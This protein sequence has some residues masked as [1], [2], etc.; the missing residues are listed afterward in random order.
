MNKQLLINGGILVAGAGLGFGAGY[1]VFKKKYA[2][3]A[4]AEIA[5][6]RDSYAK[7]A[8]NAAK[9]D[10]KDFN[11]IITPNVVKPAVQ[12]DEE[13]VEQIIHRSNYTS[14]GVVEAESF[15]AVYG[16]VPTTEELEELSGPETNDSTPYIFEG[17]IFDSPEPDPETLGEGVD[18]V[19]PRS[20]DR[21]YVIK[22]DE[23]YLNETNYDQITLTWWADDDVLAD[24]SQHPILDIESAVGA[25]NL[26][27]FGFLSMDPDIVY[28]RNEKL[29]V[30]YEITKD[31]RNFAEVVHGVRSDEEQDNVLRRMRSNDE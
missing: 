26:H 18:E 19:P 8:K 28:V 6:V 12:S 22:L 15:R 24:D 14:E 17:N 25:T 16:R 30:D 27:R 2:A 7:A 21:P 9:A 3:I 1:F 5:S 13:R 20:P 29:K 10:P 11:V 23:W 4:D 31:E